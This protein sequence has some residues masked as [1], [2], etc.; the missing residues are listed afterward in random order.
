MGGTARVAGSL[1]G[2]LEA[3]RAGDPKPA[4]LGLDKASLAGRPA[5]EA[6]EK[7]IDAVCPVDGSQ[8]TEARRD[9]LSRAISELTEEFPNVDLTALTPEQ[10]DR[11]LEVFIAHD[12]SHRIELDVGKAI[13][14]KAANYAAAVKRFE[15]MRQY[16]REK[17]S[18]VFRAKL[19]AG[20]KLTR[21]T[22]ASLMGRVIRDTLS[23]FEDY[24]R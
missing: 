2:G 1:Y 22:G 6:G 9:S 10:I 11:L 14:E 7:I 15:E 20:E 17:V 3:F 8:D 18:G 4:E 24:I 23:V 13:L 16:V 19:Q 5:R 12:I 21:N